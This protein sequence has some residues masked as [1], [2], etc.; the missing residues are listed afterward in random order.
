MSAAK[1]KKKIRFLVQIC[2]SLSSFWFLWLWLC[3]YLDS[4]LVKLQYFLRH[5]RFWILEYPNSIILC[6]LNLKNHPRAS[7]QLKKNTLTSHFPN[8]SKLACQKNWDTFVIET[9]CWISNFLLS[10]WDLWLLVLTII[11]KMLSLNFEIALVFL[12]LWDWACIWKSVIIC[13]ERT[14]Q[15]LLEILS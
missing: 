3:Q 7:N 4:D 6:N 14:C 13:R 2:F 9:W 15:T 11:R 1:I 5:A 10:I 8:K 12:N